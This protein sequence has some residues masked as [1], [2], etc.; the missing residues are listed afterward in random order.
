VCVY[1]YVTGARSRPFTYY[2]TE[3]KYNI[4]YTQW[5]RRRVGRK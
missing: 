5:W 1:K 4:I 2:M 3:H